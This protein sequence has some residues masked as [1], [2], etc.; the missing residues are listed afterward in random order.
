MS[1]NGGSAMCAQAA[2]GPA[3]AVALLAMSS[4]AG[5]YASVALA[6]PPDGQVLDVTVE[7]SRVS[8]VARDAPLADVLAAIGRQAGVKVVLRDALRTSVTATLVNVP[9]EEAIR[10]LSRW[11]SLALIYDRST[12]SLNGS[13][14]SEVWLR[15]PYPDVA[16]GRHGRSEA[17]GP[18]SSSDCRAESRPETEP[19]R[20]ARKLVALKDPKTRTR[21]LQDLLLAHGE[22]AIVAALRGLATHDPASEVRRAAVELLASR[23]SL[24]AIEAIRATL[25]DPHPEVREEAQSA[26][27]RQ[28]RAR[29]SDGSSD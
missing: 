13:V 10:R 3:V 24:D 6:A 8:L 1:E 4:A 7:S 11:H 16:G 18:A 14:L 12:G 26:L 27:R 9:L 5:P 15:S 23:G 25:A 28:R 19:E 29:T 21:H 20:L 22:P 17:A 2:P